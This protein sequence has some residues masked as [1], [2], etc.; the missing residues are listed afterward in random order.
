MEG[1]HQAHD[2]QSL[3]RGTTRRCTKGGTPQRGPRCRVR[4]CRCG[5]SSPDMHGS[6]ER[7]IRDSLRPESSWAH[8]CRLIRIPD[9]KKTEAPLASLS[10]NIRPRLPLVSPAAFQLQDM[11]RSS[12][13]IH[14]NGHHSN[15]GVRYPPA[16]AYRVKSCL[17]RN[18]PAG[19]APISDWGEAYEL[20]S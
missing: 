1:W 7:S 11:S 17:P 15:T 4:Q 14:A 12:P 5:L 19:N 3:H 20:V 13:V 16:A 2:V 6:Q 10:P 9:P 8:C 18:P